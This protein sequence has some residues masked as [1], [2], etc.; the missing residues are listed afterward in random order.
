MGFGPP[1]GYWR[2]RAERL[3]A[4]VKAAFWCEDRALFAS[5]VGKT[6]FSEHSQC[7]A[8]LADVVTGEEAEPSVALSPT[9]RYI[10]FPVRVPSMTS[11]GIARR[12]VAILDI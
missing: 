8:L 11:L 1:A 10:V 6:E 2:A 4:A 12:G 7:L 3:K 5:D 9:R